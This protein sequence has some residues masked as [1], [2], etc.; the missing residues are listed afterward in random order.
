METINCI[1]GMFK[2]SVVPSLRVNRIKRGQIIVNP[3]EKN[4][5]RHTYIDVEKEHSCL[6]CMNVAWPVICLGPEMLASHLSVTFINH[7]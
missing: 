7:K 2:T 5:K 1:H 3:E 4:V 6:W